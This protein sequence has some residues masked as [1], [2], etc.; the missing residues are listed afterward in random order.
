MWIEVKCNQK[1]VSRL[2]YDGT[3]FLSF[4]LGVLG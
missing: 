4:E 3:L 2:I 1:G